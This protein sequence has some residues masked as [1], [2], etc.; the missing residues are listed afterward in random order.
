MFIKFEEYVLLGQPFIC[1]LFVK[2]GLGVFHNYL[3]ILESIY[4]LG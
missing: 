1:S 4:I 3:F 2:L